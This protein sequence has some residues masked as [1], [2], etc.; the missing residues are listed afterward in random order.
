MK[1]VDLFRVK[2]LLGHTNLKTTQI[3]L[4][5]N[6]RSGLA[7]C[8]AVFLLCLF[9]EMSRSKRSRPFLFGGAFCYNTTKLHSPTRNCVPFRLSGRLTFLIRHIASDASDHQVFVGLRPRPGHPDTW[10]S[11]HD[12]FRL[13]KPRFPSCWP[14]EA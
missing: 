12:I 10:T 1:G 13:I 11:G 9:C 5:T 3:Y 4:H 7:I 2:T 14:S 8:W 6:D